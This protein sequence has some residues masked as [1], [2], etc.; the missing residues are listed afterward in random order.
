VYLDHVALGTRDAAGPMPTLL[1]ELGGTLVSGGR[2]TGFQSLQVHLGDGASGM[3]L[4]L[5]EPYGI[6]END[7][8]ERFVTRHGDGP[9]HLTFKV[10]DLVST[11]ERVRTAGFKP[12][13]VDLTDPNWMEAFLGPREAHGTVVQLAQGSSPLHSPLEEY[14]RTV[15]EG[16]EEQPRWW[17][18]PPARGPSTTYL[19]RVVLATPSLLSSAAFFTG[20][21]HGAEEDG[22]EGWIEI[23]WPGG[24]RVKV[25]QRSDRKPGI[26]R[27]ELEGD[28][29]SRELVV[30]GARLVANP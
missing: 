30:A 24:A 29:P 12:V 17:P 4:E 13:A 1:G 7:F 5:L 3:K 22:G 20:L 11:I 6:D 14:D 9:H 10:D 28:G 25:E 15:V 27:L 21:L 19:R 26:D 8:L 2:W 18:D 23:G 16:P